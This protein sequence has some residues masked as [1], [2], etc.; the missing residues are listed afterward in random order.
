MNKFLNIIY[1]SIV[2]ALLFTGC[3]FGDPPEIIFSISGKFTKSAAAG[4]GDVFFKLANRDN[5][6]RSPEGLLKVISNESYAIAG[7]LMDGSLTIKL[8]GSYDPVNMIYTVSADDTLVRYVINGAFDIYYNYA[9]ATA[10]ILRKDVGDNCP[11]FYF[12]V[13]HQS[14]KITGNTSDYNK[15]MSAELPDLAIGL[16]R[17]SNSNRKLR[18]II[19]PFSYICIESYQGYDDD[20]PEYDIY[21]RTVVKVIDKTNYY[22]FIAAYPVAGVTRYQKSKIEFSNGNSDM[23][24]TYY[25]NGKSLDFNTVADAEAAASLSSST[26]K[27]SR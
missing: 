7:E 26:K 6:Q 12:P 21:M 3:N 19:S 16:W 4:S 18:Y 17:W 14:V 15:G 20:Y 25:L 22:D 9:E 5:Y 2:I 10:S 13:S 24:V 23:A 27:V 8:K 1:L 11:V